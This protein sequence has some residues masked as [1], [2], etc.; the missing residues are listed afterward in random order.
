MSSQKH[1]K[2][3]IYLKFRILL[4][5][6]IIKEGDVSPPDVGPVTPQNP[7]YIKNGVKV[8]LTKNEG[9]T[10]NVFKIQIKESLGFRE[11]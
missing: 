3:A 6:E 5:I 7:F 9:G 8:N 11:I 1:V 10:G 2:K 4:I